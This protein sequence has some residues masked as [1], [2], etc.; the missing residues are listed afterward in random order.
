MRKKLTKEELLEEL[1]NMYHWSRS[2]FLEDKI[3]LDNLKQ[4]YNQL[5]EIVGKHFKE[6]TTIMDIDISEYERGL[7]DARQAQQKP[8]V[9]REWVIKWREKLLLRGLDRDIG[10]LS[11]EQICEEL[12]VEVEE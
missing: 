8:T 4:A 1:E 6:P 10:E 11:I 7:K 3:G 9:T 2:G 12:G 5:K